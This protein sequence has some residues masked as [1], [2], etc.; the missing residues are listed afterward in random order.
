MEAGDAH[1]VGLQSDGTVVAVGSS[2]DNEC[3][4]FDW[5][6]LWWTSIFSLFTHLLFLLLVRLI[7]VKFR[8]GTPGQVHEHQPGIHQE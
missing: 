4:L 6:L 1:T 3:N 8:R 2:D 5:N 7:L